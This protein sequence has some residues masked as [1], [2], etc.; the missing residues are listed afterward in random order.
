MQK[1]KDKRVKP[2][3]SYSNEQYAEAVAIILGLST[4]EITRKYRHASPHIMDAQN[5]LCH[6]IKDR[7]KVH[8]K[9]LRD[10]LNKANHGSISAQISQY[11]F[12]FDRDRFFREKAEKVLAGIDALLMQMDHANES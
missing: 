9:E 11:R 5:I 8:L 6:L 10:F 3:R 12:R 1:Q 2:V 7:E 4:A